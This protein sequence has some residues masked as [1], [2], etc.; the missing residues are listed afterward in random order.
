[1]VSVLNVCG[2]GFDSVEF[3]VI[4]VLIDCIEVDFGLFEIY[5]VNIGGLFVGDLFGFMCE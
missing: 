2:Y 3:V 5:V 4:L 1:M